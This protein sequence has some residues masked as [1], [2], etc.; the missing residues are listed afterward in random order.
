MPS[1]PPLYGP[2]TVCRGS[3]RFPQ[4]GADGDPRVVPVQTGQVT[5]K[6]APP[7]PRTEEAK[8]YMR[9]RVRILLSHLPAAASRAQPS[10]KVGEHDEREAQAVGALRRG[11]Y[12]AAPF[13]RAGDARVGARSERSGERGSR[14]RGSRRTPAGPLAPQCGAHS[15]TPSVGVPAKEC[16]PPLPVLYLAASSLDPSSLRKAS[17]RRRTDSWPIRSLRSPSRPHWPC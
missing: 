6:E 3:K 5:R 11:R 16:A 13:D 2:P 7:A 12:L 8:R 10:L 15:G 9:S 1:R 17:F 4:Q 14:R